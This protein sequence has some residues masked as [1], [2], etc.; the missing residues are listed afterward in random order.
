MNQR[1]TNPERGPLVIVSGPSGTGKSTLIRRLLD[2]RRWPLRLSVS[3]TTRP[4]RRGEVDG[5]E[6]HFWDRSRF[7]AAI[8][9]GEFLEHAEVHR[10]YYGTL[11]REVEPFRNA[12]QGVILDIDVQGAAQVRAKIPDHLSIFVYTSSLQA[13]SDRLHQRGTEDESGILRRLDVAQSELSHAGEYQYQILNDDLESASARFV[14]IVDEAISH[15][16]KSCRKT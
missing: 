1:T 12:G 9:G 8:A 7:L 13:Y 6:Y 4:P 11:Q 16:G 3:A 10:H 14:Q 2:L 5:V 15:G